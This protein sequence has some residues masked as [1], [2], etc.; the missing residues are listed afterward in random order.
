MREKYAKWDG[1]SSRSEEDI[2]DIDVD[3]LYRSFGWSKQTQW[4]SM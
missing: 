3:F 4:A 2:D 1:P